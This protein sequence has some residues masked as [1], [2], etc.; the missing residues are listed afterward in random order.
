MCNCTKYE[1]CAIVQNMKS[2]QL[3]CIE[4]VQMQLYKI[5]TLCKCTKYEICAIVQNMN[6]VQ[7]YKIW[8][9]C[10]CTKYEICAIV[11]NM[12]SVQFCTDFMFSTFLP[13]C[14][15]DNR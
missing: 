8:N 12:K 5:W 11:Q 15:H 2:V 4:T 14:L 1:L 7:L 10:N 13:A 6:S 9:L 3:N